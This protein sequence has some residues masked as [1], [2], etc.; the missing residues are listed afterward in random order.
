MDSLYFNKI[1]AGVLVALIA[2]FLS[3]H[4]GG[5]LVKP[6]FPKENAYPVEV[7]EGG[8]VDAA[9]PEEE[10]LEPISPL[11]AAAD[12]AAGEKV[13][14]K[15]VQC[16]TFKKGEP[17][18]IGPNLWNVVMS[19]PASN[20]D[21]SYSAALQKLTGTWDYEA[22]NSYLH[23]PKKHAPGTKMAFAGLAKAADRANMIAYLRA[24]SDAPAP[25][26]TAQ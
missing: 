23:K 21:F 22:L 7:P 8:H 17:H 19:K 20:P 10:K 24:H 2:A 13:A 16:H 12:L 14:K 25:L 3:V 18:K 9:K 6:T 5:E 4:I 26:P 11:L 1:A 15:C